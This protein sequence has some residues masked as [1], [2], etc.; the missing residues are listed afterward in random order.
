[1]YVLFFIYVHF[2]FYIYIFYFLY[3]YIVFVKVDKTYSLYSQRVDNMISKK[4]CQI[5]KQL[6]RI[7]YL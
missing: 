4:V 3:K 6:K 1:M 7:Q 5:I 2:T